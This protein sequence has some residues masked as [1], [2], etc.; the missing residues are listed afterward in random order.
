M[1]QE[2]YFLIPKTKEIRRNLYTIIKKKLST[3]GIKEI[4]KIFLN[5]KRIFLNQRV[6]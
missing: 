2:I 1:N 5:K 6:L 4:K 3:P